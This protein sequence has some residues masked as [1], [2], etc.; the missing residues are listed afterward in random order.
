MRACGTRFVGHKVAALNRLVDRY[1]A[2][3]AHL[4]EL[5]EDPRVKPCDK[6]RLKGYYKKWHDGKMIL[7]CAFFH[8]VLKPCASLSQA[9]QA[10]DINIVDAIEA[11]LKTNKS[12]EQLK[13]TQFSELPTVKKVMSRA[14]KSGNDNVTYQE[15]ELGKYDEA[16]TY[17]NSAKD[18]VIEA[19]MACLKDRVTIHHP[20][21]LK[22][23]LTLL[24]THGWQRS[25]V[26][27]LQIFPWII[28]C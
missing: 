25:T 2:Y 21:L 9:L 1:G 3:L 18:H 24:A 22:D 6:Q 16:V 23:C 4:L 19:I 12:I 26:T 5:T 8:D 11:V 20:Q 27:T 7:G 14:Q 10:E 13:S 15:T 17:L 28:Y